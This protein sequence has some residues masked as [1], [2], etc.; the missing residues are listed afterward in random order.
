MR[1]L[2]TGLALALVACGHPGGDL[3]V[4][5]WERGLAE[6]EG[7][8]YLDAI[9]DLKLFIRRSP[10]D[11]RA[12]DAQFHVGKAYMA[13]ED[14]PVAAVEF[15]ILRAD[16]PD[17]EFLDDAWFLE[18]MCYVEQVPPVHLA[19][20]ATQTAVRHFQRYLRE[21]PNGSRREAASEQLATLGEHLDRKRLR[22]VEIYIR[23]GKWEAALSSL[24]ALFEDR[25]DSA[26]LPEML[27]LRS[28][29]A[30]KLDD[31]ETSDAALAELVQRF[32]DSGA[33]EEARRLLEDS[34]DDE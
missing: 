29:I 31:L 19:Q 30:R 2:L 32:P 18:G 4:G 15:E 5:T 28:R 13:M 33:A 7:E 24:E 6:F 20:D 9:D 27:W 1:R 25:P 8:S 21:R 34:A 11:E 12:D 14:Y 16:Y 26:L 23:I 17:S 3:P 10:T 22:A